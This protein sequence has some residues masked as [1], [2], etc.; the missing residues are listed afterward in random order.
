M[1]ILVS[2]VRGLSL[3]GTFPP[4]YGVVCVIVVSTSS[5]PNCVLKVDRNKPELAKQDCCS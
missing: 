3:S 5:P 1:F 2:S 4:F